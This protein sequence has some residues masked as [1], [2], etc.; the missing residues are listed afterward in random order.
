MCVPVMSES[1]A[2]YFGPATAHEYQVDRDSVPKQDLDEGLAQSYVDK[3]QM[4]G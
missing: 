3:L 4:K 1:R 2:G